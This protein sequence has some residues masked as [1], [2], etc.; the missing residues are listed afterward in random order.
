MTKREKE[1]KDALREMC[2]MW[3]SYCNAMG[4]DP[5]VVQYEN[6]VKLLD[7]PSNT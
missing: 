4:Y 2:T 6:A 7:K 3:N 5:N 1:L